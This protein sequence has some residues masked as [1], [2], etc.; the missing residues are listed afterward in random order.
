VATIEIS[1]KTAKHLEKLSAK[2]RERFRTIEDYLSH[3]VHIFG[4]SDNIEIRLKYRKGAKG[5]KRSKMELD[6]TRAEYDT[7][8]LQVFDRA[9][10][11]H[12]V[13]KLEWD[14]VHEVVHMAI[15]WLPHVA[16]LAAPHA[17]GQLID[18]E[19]ERAVN[20]LEMAFKRLV[21]FY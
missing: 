9:L 19:E 11:A 21:E 3:W 8:A 6:C 7:F 13:D 20:A 5:P 17:W 4:L 12:R 2:K 15:Y 16:A 14:V 18:E 1:P 10:R